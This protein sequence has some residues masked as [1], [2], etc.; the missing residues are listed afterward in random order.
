MKK[1][2]ERPRA[3][4][5]CRD[6]HIKWLEIYNGRPGEVLA[7]RAINKERSSSIDAGESSVT[8]LRARCLAFSILST[9]LRTRPFLARW[10][11]F[12]VPPTPTATPGSFTAKPRASGE[13]TGTRRSKS[14]VG[15]S[16]RECVVS[17]SRLPPSTSGERIQ[18]RLSNRSSA[19]RSR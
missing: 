18:R 17:R 15:F 4:G 10:R 5:R 19:N 2:T 13:A 7:I 14:R 12:I 8:V 9:N 11:I 16:N 3:V 6:L 1:A